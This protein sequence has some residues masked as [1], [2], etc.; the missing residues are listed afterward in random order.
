[1][2][3]K[4]TEL[5]DQHFLTEKVEMLGNEFLLY[6]TKQSK[7]V[8]QFRAWNGT[9]QK[10]IRKSTRKKD[11]KR[12][13]L[14]ATQMYKE[15]VAKQNIETV[16]T[17]KKR[18]PRKS[19]GNK[20]LEAHVMYEG[21]VKIFRVAQSGKVWQIYIWIREE[22]K[23]IKQSLRTR[24]IDL[25][26]ERARDI[27]LDY[28]AKA[29]SNQPIFDRKAKE[30]TDAFIEHQLKRAKQRSITQGFVGTLKARMKHYL[31]FVGESTALTKI[32][33]DKFEDYR[34]FRIENAPNVKLMTLYNERGTIKALYKFAKEKSFINNGYE[35]RFGEWEKIKKSG[36]KLNRDSLSP[37]EW[38]TIY[39]HMQ[40]WH[41]KH[42]VR[43]D[44]QAEQRKFLKEFTLILCNSGIR[45]GEARKLQW[46]DIDIYDEKVIEN[47][48]QVAKKRAKINLPASKTKTGAART[49]I[50]RLGNPFIRL[51]KLSNHT[52]NEDYI[53]VDNETGKQLNK[54][55]Y[56]KEWKAMLKGTGLDKG[57]KNIVYY[58]LRHTYATFELYK[59]TDVFSLSKVLGCGIDFIQNHYGHV[60]IDVIKN[61][62]TK[63]LRDTEGGRMLL[64]N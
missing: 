9:E 32:N 24:D 12:A 40:R 58:C 33:E 19:K 31:R 56:Y 18:K 44:K 35:P 3:A 61:Q 5:V 28:I 55:V 27:Y 1:M 52:K 29:R 8:W 51:K 15:I 16:N 23:A 46:H 2:A 7:D 54:S 39:T 37:K 62:F 13:K 6:R 49:A 57:N 63:D 59:G 36:E 11:L 41:Q 4:N 25:A 17:K 64:E 22:Q 26:R 45:L 14:V 47:G 30:L 50:C 48:E 20:I 21:D 38:N 53:F 10:Y 43:N 60:E 42:L 34:A